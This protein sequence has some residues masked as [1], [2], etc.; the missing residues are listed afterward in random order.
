MSPAGGGAG[1]FLRSL[2]KGISETIRLNAVKFTARQKSSHLISFRP[3]K[4]HPFANFR[5]YHANARSKQSNSRRFDSQSGFNPPYGFVPLLSAGLRRPNLGALPGS[6]KKHRNFSG[7]ALSPGQIFAD[8]AANIAISARCAL[9]GGTKEY[10]RCN[11]SVRV[12]ISDRIMSN[13]NDGKKACLTTVNFNL[14]PHLYVSG[15][16]ALDDTFL[17]RM[18]E[19]RGYTKNA[20]QKI[21]DNLS[22][23]FVVGSLPLDIVSYGGMHLHVLDQSDNLIT[24]FDLNPVALCGRSFILDAEFLAELDNCSLF[25]D[26]NFSSIIRRLYVLAHESTPLRVVVI[27]KPMELRIKMR[28]RTAQDV[29]FLLRDLGIDGGNI[30]GQEI[31][32]K[33]SSYGGMDEVDWDFLLP[34]GF[35]DVTCF[36]QEVRQRICMNRNTGG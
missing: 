12:P 16:S 21:H 27:E 34:Q 7:A 19:A 20:F 1:Y 4:R 28:G 36:I 31:L 11:A 3:P 5:S 30:L 23:L 33:Y 32:P 9:I 22:R 17:D 25:C 29:E 18:E 10:N 24:S 15:K 6:F 2:V 13:H 14:N 26:R 8:V 35:Q